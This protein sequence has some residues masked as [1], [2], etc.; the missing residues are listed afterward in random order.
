MSGGIG[1]MGET[2]EGASGEGFEEFHAQYARTLHVFFRL[3]GLNMEDSKDLS[4][5]TWL[6]FRRGWE[7]YRNPNTMIFIIA[8]QN[9]SR[10]IER[11]KINLLVDRDLSSM[12][13]PSS[14]P[15]AELSVTH[16][17]MQR[18]DLLRALSSL[19]E[20]QKT[21]L[22][23]IY[24]ADLKQADVAMIMGCGVANVKKLAANAL[25]ALEASPALEGYQNTGR[26]P[27]GGGA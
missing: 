24:L 13:V 21:V 1:A 10:W 27:A 9:F 16:E 12:H 20:R 6:D 23:L 4:Q 11:R 8:R 15:E 25:A 3:R 2:P 17:S 26:Q 18:V 5:Q 14:R 19:P 7:S 22:F